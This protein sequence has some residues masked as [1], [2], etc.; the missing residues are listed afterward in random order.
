MFIF[1]SVPLRKHVLRRFMLHLNVF[2]PSPYG[3]LVKYVRVCHAVSRGFRIRLF[4]SFGKQSQMLPVCAPHGIC[5]VII[6]ITS[7]HAVYTAQFT[8]P[9]QMKPED[10]CD[11]LLAVEPLHTGTSY[12]QLTMT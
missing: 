11:S 9:E 6:Y 1:A 4:W 3:T 12:C 8:Q 2:L 5:F 7:G 10:L